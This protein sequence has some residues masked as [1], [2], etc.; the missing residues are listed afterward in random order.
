MLILLHRVVVASDGAIIVADINELEAELLNTVPTAFGGNIT[1]N[2]SVQNIL[3][4]ADG[5]FVQ[6][7]T[8]DIGGTNYTFTFDGSNITVTPALAGIDIDG[9]SLTLGPAV[10]GFTLGTFTFDFADGS[11][12]FSSPNGNAG[13]QLL[14][15]Y[16]VQDGDGDTAAATATI[17]IIDNKPTANDDLDSVAPLDVAAGNVINAQG[18]DG[19]PSFGN[20]FTPFASQGSG[21]DT[22]VDSADITQVSFRGES[23]TLDFDSGSVPAGGTSGTLSW[24]YSTTTNNLGEEFSVVTVTD[25]ADNAQLIFNSAGYYQFTPD[26]TYTPPAP[27]TVT[28]TSQANI[29]AS[30]IDVTI[31]TGGTTL[32]F[33]ADG[34]GVTGGNGRLLSQGE[35]IIVAFDAIALPAGASDVILTMDDFQSD[36]ND[37]MT[38]IVTHDTDGDGTLNTDTIVFSASNNNVEVLDLSQFTGVTA[39]DVEYTGTGYDS[40]L[41]NVTYTP[42]PTSLPASMLPEIINYTLTD[43]DAQTDTAQLSIYAIDNTITG[44]VNA[45]SI[46]GGSLNDAITGDAGNDNLSGG[47]GHD[48]ISGG[49]GDDTLFGG[50]GLDNLLGGEGDDTLTGGADADYL[51]GG[52][53]AD[54]LDGGTGDDIV[55]GGAGD[56]LIFGGAGN[57]QLE[58]GLGNNSLYGGAGDDS[59]LGGEGIDFLYGGQGDDTL[60][61]GADSDVFVWNSSDEGTTVS[62]TNDTITDFTT[63]AGGD[64]LNL[65]NL[66]QGEEAAPLTDFLHF[67]SDGNGGTEIQVDANGGGTFET[68]QNI[69]LEGIDLTAGGSLSDQDIINSLLAGGNLIVD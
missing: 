67:Q 65:S 25:S 54:L 22:I 1:A 58:G 14:F 36:F 49:V 43:S 63:G 42:V 38:V 33:N 61:G 10:P 13:N 3:F 66:L 30:D 69:G 52:E 15:D 41:R 4:G 32:D 6:E 48:T 5:G 35:A 46:V 45:D 34:V 11:Y 40:G 68:V 18:T 55:K 28:T 21:V 20:N 39:L 31:R 7:I 47:A 19:G 12:T 62:P 50:A 8:T 57:D 26:T 37:Q 56:D 60:T 2:G 59:L 27:V 17:D 29:N 23:L 24:T 44:T 64:V 53:G 51:A 16:I 9:S